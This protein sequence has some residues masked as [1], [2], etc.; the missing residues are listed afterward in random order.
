MKKISFSEHGKCALKLGGLCSL[1]YFVVYI[2]RNLLSAVTP[3]MIESGLFTA[4]EIGSISSAFFFTYAIGQLI[5]GILGDR[6]RPSILISFGLLFAGAANLIFT[7]FPQNDLIALISYAATGFFLSML[8]APMTRVMAENMPLK[9][10]TRCA[11]GLNVASYFASPVVGVFAALFLWQMVFHIGTVLL[12]IM[13]VICLISF[14]LLRRQNI[15]SE[16]KKEIEKKEHSGIKS[17]FRHRIITF[18]LVSALTGIIRT[19]VVF[20]M[21]TF[22]SQKLGY[23]PES[24]ALIFTVST[25]LIATNAFAA[26]WFYKLLKENMDLTLLLSFGLSTVFFLLL[27]FVTNPV[28]SILLMVLAIFFANCA[29]SM[30]WS[31]YCPSLADTGLVSGATGF[32][33]F[34]SYMAAAISSSLFGNAVGTIGWDALILVW[35]ALMLLGTFI[36]IPFKKKAK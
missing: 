4:D 8:Y 33:D 29:A 3:Q 26:V 10:A 12:F 22:F 5:N 6:M 20:W 32:L 18:T 23:S 11:L 24:A 16:T 31:I 34:V 36:T 13:G 19:S 25:T 15:I 17:L 27:Y 30:L 35:F 7:L 9:Y 2:V 21:P 14:S 28:L 1:S